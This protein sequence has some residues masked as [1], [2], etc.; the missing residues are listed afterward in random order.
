M[1]P[2]RKTTCVP[3]NFDAVAAL[4]EA[5]LDPERSCYGR[6]AH[7]TFSK[8]KTAKLCFRTLLAHG[9]PEVELVVAQAPLQPKGG[10]QGNI[11]AE[12]RMLRVQ[13]V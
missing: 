5:A 9:A 10:E 2:L 11:D 8:H 6:N 3:Q 13:L 1:A 4:V 7:S 12:E